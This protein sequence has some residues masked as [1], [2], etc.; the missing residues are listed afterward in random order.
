MGDAPADEPAAPQGAPADEAS[1]AQKPEVEQAGE[2]GSGSAKNGQAG[3]A[4]RRPPP[5]MEELMAMSKEELAKELIDAK[6]KISDLEAYT[7]ELDGVTDSLQRQLSERQEADAM[8]PDEKLALKDEVIRSLQT[9]IDRL[10]R[11]LGGMESADMDA[12]INYDALDKLDEE[13]AQAKEQC[14]LKDAEIANLKAMEEAARRDADGAAHWREAAVQA[15]ADHRQLQT[16]FETKDREA[17]DER[18]MRREIEA[19]FEEKLKL[20]LM[21]IE[22]LTAEVARLRQAGEQI[23]PVLTE[24]EHVKAESRH[25]AEHKDGE[26]KTLQDALR[27]TQAHRQKAEGRVQVMQSEMEQWTVKVKNA[28][29]LRWLAGMNLAK[30]KAEMDWRNKADQEKDFYMERMKD[31]MERLKSKLMRSEMRKLQVEESL[32]EAVVELRGKKREMEQMKARVDGLLMALQSQGHQGGG[33]G[34][35]DAGNAGRGA[36]FES[37]VAR[38]R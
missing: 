21:E 9:E 12:G 6:A 31:E 13:L 5:S 18:K 19:R 35:G 7:S 37:P 23:G 34:V 14:L 2:R 25:L 3:G 20:K 1:A 16:E 10:E 30:A 27:E 28:E 4:E 22:R 15:Q 36:K 26:I 33:M 11:E 24:L 8:D 17:E 29:E 38:R 32:G